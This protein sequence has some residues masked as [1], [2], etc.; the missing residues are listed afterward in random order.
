MGFEKSDLCASFSSLITLERLSF[1]TSHSF[2]TYVRIHYIVIM[3]LSVM[4][5]P[6]STTILKGL[7]AFPLQ[8]LNLWGR[9]EGEEGHN[10]AVLKKQP[11]RLKISVQ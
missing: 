1:I 11:S 4:M 8:T 3:A 9:M 10:S 2:C 5:A 6:L 7:S